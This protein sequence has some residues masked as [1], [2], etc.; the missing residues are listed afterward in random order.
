M[1]PLVATAQALMAP[2]KVLLALAV[3][4]IGLALVE[5]QHFALHLASVSL[6]GM[7]AHRPELRVIDFWNELPGHLPE[8]LP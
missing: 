5:G 6:L 7:A 8:E 1:S 4:W 3:R 2:G